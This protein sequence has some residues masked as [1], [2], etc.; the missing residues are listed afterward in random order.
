MNVQP[1]DI[2]V[3]N[4]HTFGS[5]EA[6]VAAEALVD[7]A[8]TQMLVTT[9]AVLIT[10]WYSCVFI[11]ISGLVTSRATPLLMFLLSPLRRRRPEET[12]ILY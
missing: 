6:L 5:A 3:V 12:P 8:R 4:V 7:I 2:T 9:S 10:E 11:L 1:P